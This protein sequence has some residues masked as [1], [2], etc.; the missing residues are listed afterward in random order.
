MKESKFQSDLIKEL[1]S[2]FPGCLILKNDPNYLQG[3]PDLLVLYKNH[4]AML[5]CKR[6][7]V[8]S[9][10]FNQDYYIDLC[11][12]MSYASFVCPENKA[13]VLHEIQQAFES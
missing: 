9:R 3:I 5:E 10:R 2:L 6:S 12:E 1:E 13:E 4:W 7:S 11:N 8:A